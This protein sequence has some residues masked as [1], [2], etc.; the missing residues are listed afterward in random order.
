MNRDRKGDLLAMYEAGDESCFDEAVMLYEKA[1]EEQPDNLT[2]LHDYGFLFEC[3]GKRQLRKAAK[4]LEKG[5]Q[6]AM[7]SDDPEV[8]N[9]PVCNGQ[10]IRVYTDLGQLNK[11]IDLFKEYITKVPDYPAGYYNLTD[12]YLSADQIEEARKEINAAYKLFPQDGY[13]SES[14]GDISAREGKVEEALNCWSR[15][16]ELN[17]E[18]ISSRFSRAYLLES[19]KR[20]EEA[21]EE[22]KI[23][24]GFLK[25]RGYTI[26]L[27]FPE[28]ELRRVEAKVKQ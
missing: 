14:M 1:L 13:I 25:E 5:V 20:F 11:A 24:I 17:K 16:M 10:L 6:I 23:I 2:L 22:W 19:E 27:A 4:I 26:E 7:E 9:N 21:V 28:G 15:A 3:N 8:K 12:A 18:I